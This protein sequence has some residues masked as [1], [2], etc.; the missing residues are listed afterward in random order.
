MAGSQMRG[1][2]RAGLVL[3]VCVLALS[4]GCGRPSRVG[5]HNPDAH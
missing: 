1:L 4:A 2:C 5:R 3:L